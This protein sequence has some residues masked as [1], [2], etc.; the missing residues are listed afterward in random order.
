MMARK[1]SMLRRRLAPQRPAACGG[2]RGAPTNVDLAVESLRKLADYGAEKNIVVN[3]ENDSP[4]R[5]IRSF[6]CRSLRRPTIPICAPP[7]F[8][9]PFAGMIR[10]TTS[11][12]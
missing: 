4:A 6:S 5:R 10:N 7:D 3:L 9:I 2:R 12:P 11:A 1:E 8:A